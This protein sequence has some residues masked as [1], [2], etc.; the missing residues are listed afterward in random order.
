LQILLT[1]R[2]SSSI[3]TA[4]TLIGYFDSF[5]FE[6]I[7]SNFGGAVQFRSPVRKNAHFTDAQ[8]DLN[9]RLT[10]ERQKVA[11]YYLLLADCTCQLR[12]SLL[13]FS[14]WVMRDSTLSLH[15]CHRGESLRNKGRVFC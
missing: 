5:M 2:P 15:N 12:V 4:A 1:L 14:E 10:C 7:V 9:L 6:F 11:G 3:R 13:K 8:S